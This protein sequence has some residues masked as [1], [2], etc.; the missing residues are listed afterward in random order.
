MEL[1]N[2]IAVLQQQRDYARAQSELEGVT[3]QRIGEVHDAFQKIELEG[4]EEI[5]EKAAR[6]RMA[7]RNTLAQLDLEVPARHG[8]QRLEEIARQERGLTPEHL[9]LEA[10]RGL[11]KAASRGEPSVEE[12]CAALQAVRDTDLLAAD[13]ARATVLYSS[14]PRPGLDLERFLTYGNWPEIV[15]ARA[16]F[17][18]AARAQP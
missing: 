5:I 9:A 15:E 14:R 11:E 2:A 8:R 12:A 6:L 1:V 10:L 7:A 4:P 13:E 16:E 3:R 17:V 18:I